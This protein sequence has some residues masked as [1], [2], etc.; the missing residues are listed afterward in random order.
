[1]RVSEALMD[2]AL[3]PFQAK[4]GLDIALVH[5]VRWDILGALM[6]NAYLRS[7]HSAFFFLEML[8]VYEAG[9]F[10]CGWQGEWPKG[11]LLVY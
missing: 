4:H 8:T 6:E 11:R 10:P 7:G 1:M 3:V 5:S 9:R 2:K